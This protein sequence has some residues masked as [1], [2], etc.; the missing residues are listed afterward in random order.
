LVERSDI[1]AVEPAAVVGEA[2][3]ALV[4]ANSFLEKFGGDAIEDI[5]AAYKAYLAR[6]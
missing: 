4:L 6:I 3:V 5:A 1:C 2:V